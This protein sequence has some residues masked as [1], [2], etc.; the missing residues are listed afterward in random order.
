MSLPS[1]RA[2][3]IQTYKTEKQRVFQSR[4]P[5]PYC[6]NTHIHSVGIKT[7]IQHFRCAHCKKSFNTRTGTSEWW[8][9]LR[10]TFA[11]YSLHMLS[12]GHAPLRQMCELFGISLKTAFD[13]RHKVLASINVSAESFN[14]LTELRQT[15]MPLNLKGHRQAQMLKN[16]YPVQMMIAASYEQMAAVNIT[17]IGNLKLA[18]LSARLKYRFD[19]DCV[20]IG[21]YHQLL[22]RFARS[23]RLF[24]SFFSNK[25]NPHQLSDALARSLENK[26]HSIAIARTRGV[27]TKY[28]QH[29]VNWTLISAPD[30]VKVELDHLKVQ[31]RTNRQ[32]WQGFTQAEKHYAAFQK[33]HSD[34]SLPAASGRIWKNFA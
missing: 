13:W 34:V 27:A 23:N 20:L 28:L 17:R 33:Q 16:N 9:H 10:S 4:P 24:V 15:I 11:L 7:G 5:C 22:A 14:G 21:R 31:A 25:H 12:H 26:M 18:D 6:A 32:A 19:R 30:V 1:L 3:L 29:Y 2:S 8:L